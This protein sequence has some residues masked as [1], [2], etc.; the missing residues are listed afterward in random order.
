MGLSNIARLA[1]K[2]LR[3][4]RSDRVMLFL[5][6]YVFT[7]A[8]YLVADAISTEI[9]DLST[10]A[11]DEDQSELSRRLIGAVQEP[12]FRQPEVVDPASAAVGLKN[13]R[14]VLAMTI[15]PDF[16]RNLRQGKSATIFIETDAT[17]VAHA[18]NGVNFLQQ[19]IAAETRAY[20]SP[21]AHAGGSVNVVVRSRFNPNLTSSWFSSVMQLMNSITILTLILA[22]ASM[23][24]ERERGT[25]EHVLV[26]PVRPHEIV[27]S[28]II[29]NGLVILLSAVL[30]LV[31]VVHQLVGVPLSGS[32]SLF[33]GGTALYVLVVASI[34]L[35]LSSF[36]QSMGQFG[37]LAIPVIIVMI[38]LSGGMTPMESMP[39]WLQLA[40]N[41]I[42]P[43]PHF[44]RFIQTVLYRGGGFGLVAGEIAAMGL[45][46][47][48][49]LI[50]VLVRFRKVLAG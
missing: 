17:A 23:I 25:I 26:M 10:V 1:F 36:T 37:L 22:G 35:L 38:L 14:Y 32:L 42:S 16:E 8:T 28:K 41:V 11:V 13:G 24:R 3:S 49:A 19:V 6:F 18:G 20:L 29:A 31:L 27:F 7:F 47:A 2:E 21:A 48:V 45:M 9:R 33:V 39:E 12:L 15:P 34:G 5:I 40:M 43:A 30:S 50:I 46:A 44:V 4:I